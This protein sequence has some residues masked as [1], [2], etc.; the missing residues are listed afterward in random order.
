M[1]FNIIPIMVVECSKGLRQLGI[2]VLKVDNTMV[3]DS[4]KEDKIT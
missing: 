3:I 4:I 1:L 2:A